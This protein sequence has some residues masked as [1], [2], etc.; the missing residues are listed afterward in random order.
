M[1]NRCSQTAEKIIKSQVFEALT[2][3]A[4]ILYSVD[5][6]IVSTDKLSVYIDK[7]KF[8]RLCENGCINYAKKWSCPPFAPHFVDFVKKWDKLCIF[9]L[10]INLE[11]FSYIKHDHLKIKAAN[12]IMKS[13]ADRFLRNMA[14]KYGKYISSGSCRL[15]KP[16]KCK[17]GLPCIHSDT[18]T[19]SPEAMGVDVGRLVDELFG[20]PLLWYKP[21]SLP[22]YTSIVCGLLTNDAFTEEELY[23]EYSKYIVK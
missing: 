20:K 13:R 10:R 17:M 22:K 8:C 23:Y 5:I 21:H 7:E 16:C 6:C 11:Q 2:N 1:V 18:M 15:C 12:S 3:S 14:E 9:Y 19:Y 4:K